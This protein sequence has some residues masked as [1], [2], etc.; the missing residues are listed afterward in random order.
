M[1]SSFQGESS[2]VQKQM[3]MGNLFDSLSGKGFL[4]RQKRSEISN[5]HE[6]SFSRHLAR[7]RRIPVLE[8][9]DSD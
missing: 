3:D 1:I 8:D 9:E 4:A 6:V 5:K 2:G 7:F